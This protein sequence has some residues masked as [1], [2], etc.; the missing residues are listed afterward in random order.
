MPGSSC[1]RDGHAV[2][3]P[4][5]LGLL[6]AGEALDRYVAGFAD[7]AAA[8]NNSAQFAQKADEYHRAAAG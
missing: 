1:G 3:G 7:F 6:R 8:A 2:D 5:A 4:V